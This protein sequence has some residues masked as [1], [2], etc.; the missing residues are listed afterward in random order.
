MRAVLFDLDGTLLPMDQ[1]LFVKAYLRELGSKG[2]ALGLNPQKF[3][4][5]VMVGL[6]AM[7]N[8]DGSQTNEALFW[9]VFVQDFG[10]ETE[11]YAA[12]FQRFYSNEF[13]RVASAV[14]PTPLASEYMRLLRAKGYD[15]VLATNP[16][17]PKA[18]TLERMRW[19]GL[20]PD[21]FVLITTYEDFSFA[22]PNP[23]YYREILEVI[24]AKAEDCLMIGNDVQEDLAAKQVGM[25]VFL[26]TDDLINPDGLD[27]SQFK[28]G[29]RRAL[30]EMI[31]AL[32]PAAGTGGESGQ[33]NL[34]KK[35]K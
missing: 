10:P 35:I 31:T 4:R 12:E 25:E 7:I 14:S 21:D 24:G 3:V 8:N 19:A 29:D 32:P 16:V 17:F 30:L 22:K 23:N 2:A 20:D 13:R 15:L 18:A 9:Q 1:D 26:V 33:K 6:E 5:T 28:R 27:I 34:I 11:K